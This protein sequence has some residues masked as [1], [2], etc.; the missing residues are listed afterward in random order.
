LMSG[1]EMSSKEK[2]TRQNDVQ[3]KRPTS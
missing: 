1:S 2:T 3:R